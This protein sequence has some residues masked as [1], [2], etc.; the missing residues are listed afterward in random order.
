MTIRSLVRIIE[1]EGRITDD[2]K[3]GYARRPTSLCG[4]IQLILFLS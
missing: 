4:E 3:E 1:G 2:T